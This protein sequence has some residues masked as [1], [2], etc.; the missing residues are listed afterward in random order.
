MRAELQNFFRRPFD[1]LY[2]S[3]EQLIDCPRAFVAVGIA[4]VSMTA[5]W[6]VYVPIHELL[7]V[8]GCLVTGGEVSVLEIQ[9]IYFGNLLAKM[10]DFVVVG[11]EYAGRLSG[12]DTHGSD[13]VYLATVFGPYLLTIFI[14]VPVLRMCSRR[15]RPLLFGPGVVIGLAPLYN[16]I[17]DYYEMASILTTRAITVLQ[18]GGQP[19]AYGSLRSDDLLSLLQQFVSLPVELGLD[20][21][22]EVWLGGLIIAIS[23][24]GSLLLAFGTYALGTTLCELTAREAEN[25]N[26][27]QEATR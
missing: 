14:G 13:L 8:A 7:H 5:T 21:G 11:S 23:V 6:F 22:S 26:D 18:G 1:D 17:G 19:P 2:D 24:A 27:E 16:F 15:S 20:T 25:H 3:I 4:L 12:F 10:F 9:E